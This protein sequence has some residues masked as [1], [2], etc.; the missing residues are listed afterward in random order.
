MTNDNNIIIGNQSYS[1]REED[2]L[3]SILKF[4]PENPRIYSL[5]VINGMTPEQ[6][7]IE[8]RVARD[9]AC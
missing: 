7:E 1:F 2:L 6:K 5:L 4:Y 3:Q 9:G 8:D